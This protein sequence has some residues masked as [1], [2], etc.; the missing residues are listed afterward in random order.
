M[1]SYNFK[2]LSSVSRHRM[3][4]RIIYRLYWLPLDNSQGQVYLPTQRF[5]II[6]TGA[7]S[8]NIIYAMSNLHFYLCCIVNITNNHD[9]ISYN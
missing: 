6:Y 1:L 7:D 3:K 8:L 9:D 5:T 4:D 2:I